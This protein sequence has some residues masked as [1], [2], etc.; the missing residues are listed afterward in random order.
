MITCDSDSLPRLPRG[1]QAFRDPIRELYQGRRQCRFQPLLRPPRRPHYG[2]VICTAEC[3]LW[4]EAGL[5]IAHEGRGV[6]GTPAG[7]LIVAG[8]SRERTILPVCPIIIETGAGRASLT[9]LA[10]LAVRS[11]RP[12]PWRARPRSS[13]DLVPARNSGPSSSVT[14]LLSSSAAG[15]RTPFALDQ[16][17]LGLTDRGGIDSCYFRSFQSSHSTSGTH[18]KGLVRAVLKYT[19]Y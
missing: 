12:S 9:S 5:V 17:P 14:S 2:G 11:A 8:N 4:K 7:D 10:L 16:N 13:P 19:G 1:C 18:E 15:S 6:V 3:Q